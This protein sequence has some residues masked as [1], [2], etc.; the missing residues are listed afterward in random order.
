M[1]QTPAFQLV[2]I[3]TPGNDKGP[4]SNA[5]T[6]FNR[7]TAR[8]GELEQAL[9]DFR[10]AATRLQQRIQTEYEPLLREFNQIRA[11][12]LRVF[13]RAH[14][15][16][17][18]TRSEKRK[19]AALIVELAH[20]L[21]ENHDLDELKPIF[22]TYAGE[23]FE[24]T[25]SRTEE[26][27]S[28]EMKDKVRS[29]YGISFDENADIRTN[30][31]FM[32]Y[33]DEQIKARQAEQAARQRPTGKPGSARKQAREAKKRLDERNT[34]KAVRT[35][36]MDLVKAFH[37]DREPDEAEKVRKT[38]IM[39][40]VTEAYQKSDLLSLLR[41]QLEFNRIDQQHLETLADEQL[42]YYNRILKQQ[43]DE[44]SAQ[45]VGLQN[46]LSALLGKPVT[47]TMSV[48]SLAFSLNND[49]RALKK[50]INA[51]RTD[52]K[53]LANPAVMKAWLK[54]YNA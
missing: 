28:E 45:L 36:Y 9:T 21:I 46:Q 34:T 53:N 43:A 23:D 51:T 54:A 29:M 13:D 44:L 26:Q 24:T 12:L 31:Q 15:R 6:E 17:E 47:R 14:N 39:Q 35:L 38:E 4:L 7:L 2:R 37:P 33:V 40:R 18:V 11:S 25:R 41:L 22:N 20:D 16:P 52:V 30:E 5:Q 10:A 42:T 1:S 48:E 3:P 50:A 32:A 27:V 8:I 19:L 49:I